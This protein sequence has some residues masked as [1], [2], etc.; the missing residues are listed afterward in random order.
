MSYIQKKNNM[1][2]ELEHPRTVYLTNE[3]WKLLVEIALKES[4][5]ISNSRSLA[6]R[7]LIDDARKKRKSKH[8]KSDES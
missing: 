8:A 1:N 2:K 5:G 7:K 6:I 4:N 3:D